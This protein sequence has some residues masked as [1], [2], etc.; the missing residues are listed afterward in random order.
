MG[1]KPVSGGAMGQVRTTAAAAVAL[2]LLA[3]NGCGEGVETPARDHRT[4][5]AAPAADDGAPP[6]QPEGHRRMLAL[7]AEIAERSETENP[8]VGQGMASRV[9]ADLAAMAPDEILPKRWLV[10]VVLAKEELRLGNAERA[11]ELYEEAYRLLGESKDP[12]PREHLFRTLFETGVAYLRW[13]ETRNCVQRHTSD[14]C[15]VPI[16]ENGV[17]VDQEGSLDAVRYLALAAEQAVPGSREALRVRWLLNLAFMTLGRYPEG[18]PEA[19]R[20]PPEAF[21]SDEPFPR[22]REIA[23][24]V[25]LGRFDLAG[26]AI[27]EDFDGDGLLDLMVSSSDTAGQIRLYRSNGDGTFTER[28]RAAGLE[29]LYGGLNANHADYDND[30]DADVLVLRGGW[31]RQL[32]RHPKSLLR[33]SGDG[34]FTDVTFEAGLGEVHYPTQTGAWADYD[35]DGDLDLF[36]GNESGKAIRFDDAK[37]DDAARYPCQL[38][39]N[40]G[41]GTFTDVAAAAGVENYRYAKGAVWGDFDGDRYP[42]LYVSNGGQPNRLYRNRTD[43]TFVD[44]APELGVTQ[45][46]ASFP[47]WSGDVNQDGVLD[48]FVGAYGG[49]QLPPDSASVVAGLLGL[50][51]PGGELPRL[52]LGDGRGGFRDVAAEW[53]LAR[54]TLPMGLNYGDLDNDGHLDFYLGTGYPYYEGLVPNVMYRNRGGT[55]F[56]DVTTAG[57]FGHLQ[58]GHGVCFADLDNDGDQDVFERVGGAWRGD[59]YGNA[60]WENPGFGNGWIKVSLVGA[61]SNRSGIGAWIRID[62]VEEGRPRTI[63][64]HVSTGGSFGDNPLRQEIGLGRAERIVALEVLWPASDRKQRFADVPAGRWIEITEG[65]GSYRELEL[66][67]FAFASGAGPGH[68]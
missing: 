45:P 31:W 53:N 5:L 10:R 20:I 50:P 40:E 36:V 58:K 66:R 30:G 4:H 49:P 15:L 25:G 17:H 22:F 64:R 62:V 42:D 57:G 51:D 11:I 32:G 12:V 63:W 46:M 68:R 23:P 2:G 60:L 65:E 34:T 8:Y 29:G 13:G 43:G 37:G 59:A 47:V 67:S 28:T 56:A 18:V 26:G 33:N 55:G 7:L 6:V 9:R 39:R 16:R 24:E 54:P 1:F 27:A 14:S 52:Y 21:R 3:G 38:F 41:D 19:Y 48:L 35:L 61:R 44:V